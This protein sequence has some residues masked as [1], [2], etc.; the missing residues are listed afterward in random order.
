MRITGK[1]EHPTISSQ[2]EKPFKFSLFH[3]VILGTVFFIFYAFS[4]C[5]SMK[6]MEYGDKITQRVRIEQE[7]ASLQA[8]DRQL[9]QQIAFLRTNE[10][11]E[12]VAREKLGF[13]KPKEIAF[14]VISTPTPSTPATPH[15][16][17]IDKEKTSKLK[18]EIIRESSKKEGWIRKILNTLWRN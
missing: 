11:V 13:I 14:V 4:E 17:S 2:T 10:G 1:G 5:Y 15:E 12:Q 6:K 18:E 9:K 8:E 7:I 16:P 3:F